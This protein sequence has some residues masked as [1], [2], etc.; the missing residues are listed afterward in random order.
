MSISSWANPLMSIRNGHA[1][2]AVI[3]PS[4]DQADYCY[5]LLTD[6]EQ[7][8]YTT[9]FVG[10]FW[11]FIPNTTA[12]FSPY[13]ARD[14]M[15]LDPGSQS[16]L[17]PWIDV[18]G[19]TF[20]VSMLH[21]AYGTGNLMYTDGKTY[22]TVG[23]HKIGWCWCTNGALASRFWIDNVVSGISG[24]P[25]TNSPALMPL[26]M[27]MMFYT[28]V[29]FEIAGVFSSFDTNLV[30]ADVLYFQTKLSPHAPVFMGTGKHT[31]GGKVV[32][33]N[34]DNGRPEMYNLATG[35]KLI[36][37]QAG[38]LPVPYDYQAHLINI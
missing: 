26:Q 17:A 14:N 5:D 30:D 7:A 23:W 21:N 36:Q 2:R 28:P 16:M 10:F 20:K 3:N 35:N 31:S 38:V 27:A 32:T 12:S 37:Q 24:V 29:G 9:L 25:S 4:I 22:S 8:N 19:A 6:P 13:G 15:A 33:F 1:Y 18:T 11:V 34:L